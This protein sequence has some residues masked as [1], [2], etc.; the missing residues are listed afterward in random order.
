MNK[1]DDNI[2]LKAGDINEGLIFT[3]VMIRN[4]SHHRCR[5]YFFSY[6]YMYIWV[7]WRLIKLIIIFWPNQNF[8]VFLKRKIIVVHWS[9]VSTIYILH[10]NYMDRSWVT[11]YPSI[12]D[13][14][15]KPDLHCYISASDLLPQFHSSLVD[16]VIS[17]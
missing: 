15:I 7:T 9:L 3:S 12:V 5:V 6:I 2:R 16:L 10:Y 8:Y 11:I 4:L 17:G 1:I 14:F 13:D